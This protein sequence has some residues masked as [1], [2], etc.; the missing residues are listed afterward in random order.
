MEGREKKDSSFS[1]SGGA[2]KEACLSPSLQGVVWLENQSNSKHVVLHMMKCLSKPITDKCVA[3][4]LS[5][6]SSFPLWAN[7]F[8]IDL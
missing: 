7:Q 8:N 3:S 4:F 2:A 1:Y 5:W 6:C